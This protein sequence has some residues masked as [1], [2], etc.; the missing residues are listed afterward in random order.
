MRESNSKRSRVFGFVTYTTV[1]DV[2]IA[3]NARPH[4]VDGRVVQPKRALS[5]NILRD[6]VPTSM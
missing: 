5:R 6:Q 2:D 3:V 4:K 1:E